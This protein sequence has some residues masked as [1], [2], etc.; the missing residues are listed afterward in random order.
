[1]LKLINNTNC[2][3]YFF[4]VAVICCLND[5]LESI[6]TPRYLTYSFCSIALPFITIVTDLF[7]LLMGLKITTF[8][9]ETL[10]ASLLT[11]SQVTSFFNSVLTINLKNI[12]VSSANRKNFSFLCLVCHLCNAKIARDP[13]QILVGLHK[14]SLLFPMC[15]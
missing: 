7:G 5:N 12:L 1:M 2:S 6:N 11:F 3:G 10:K 15:Y 9:L 4:V 14:R 13:A 8:V